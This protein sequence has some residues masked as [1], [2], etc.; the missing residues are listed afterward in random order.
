MV[1]TLGCCDSMLLCYNNYYRPL[2]EVPHLP[3]LKIQLVI[4]ILK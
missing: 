4:I 2:M 1:M 3:H